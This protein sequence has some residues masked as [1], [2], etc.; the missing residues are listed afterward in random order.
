MTM[1][2]YRPKATKLFRPA[3]PPPPAPPRP[4]Q[5]RTPEP[6]P[7][8][9]PAAPAAKRAPMPLREINDII[10]AVCR[11]FKV[12]RLELTSRRRAEAIVNGRA[13]VIRLAR[14]HTRLSFPQ[15]AAVLLR[16]NHSSVITALQR[17]DA[18][19]A[20]PPGEHER[21]VEIT[22]EL[23]D[24]GELL[25]QARGVIAGDDYCI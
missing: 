18:V 6:Q 20:L 24:V 2:T 1:M 12:T 8:V 4:E 3:P 7:I 15:I 10:E 19:L 17:L 14:D 22:G 11:L 13:V 5:A 9:A 16:P 25:E 23:H 21:I